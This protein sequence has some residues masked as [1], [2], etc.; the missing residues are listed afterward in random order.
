LLAEDN[1]VNQRVAAGILNKRGHTVVVVG[2]GA[3][4]VAALENQR[5]D[6]VLMDVQMPVMDGVE[7]TAAIR[8][9]ERIR[10][11]H[12]PIIAMTAH[13]MTGDRQHFLQCGMDN[14]ISKPVRPQDLFSAIAAVLSLRAD[15]AFSEQP[16]PVRS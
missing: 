14:Y 12:L 16:A 11:G 4:A 15:P 9:R 13:A 1:L 7:A 8:E 2:D 5:F 6:V 3:Q 10:G